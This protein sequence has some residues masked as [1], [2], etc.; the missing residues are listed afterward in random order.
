MLLGRHVPA[1]R[2]AAGVRGCLEGRA[3]HPKASHL[4]RSFLR[5]AGYSA[6]APTG[7]TLALILSAHCLPLL[8]QH[9]APPTG[10]A[11]D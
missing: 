6:A 3:V 11:L 4:R 10:D 5:K 9:A 7:A 8:R 1:C 2:T